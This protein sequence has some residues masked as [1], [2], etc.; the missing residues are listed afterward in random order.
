VR[1]PLLGLLKALIET[2]LGALGWPW[3]CG[4][5]LW[6]DYLEVRLQALRGGGR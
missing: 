6:L 4:S 3:R 2:A 5:G 1:R